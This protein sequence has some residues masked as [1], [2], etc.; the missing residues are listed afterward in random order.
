MSFKGVLGTVIMRFF[1]LN[2]AKTGLSEF[3]ADRLGYDIETILITTDDKPKYFPAAI[4][5]D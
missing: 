4:Y 2:I 3:E 1:D 5:Y